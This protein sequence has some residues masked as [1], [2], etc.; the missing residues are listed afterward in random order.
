MDTTNNPILSELAEKTLRSFNTLA[1]ASDDMTLNINNSPI[2]GLVDI[3]L[4]DAIF[5]IA[6]DIHIEPNTAILNIRFRIDGLLYEYAA[7]PLALHPF[8]VARLKIIS[9]LNTVEKRKPQDGNLSYKYLDKTVDIRVAVIPTIHGE[10]IVLR[11]LNTSG[12]LLNIDELNLSAANKKLFQK[13]YT[14]PSGLILNTGPVNSGKTT[15]LYAALQEL[16]SIEKNIMTIEDPVE[17]KLDGI[18]QVQINELQGLNFNIGLRAILRQ[19]PNIVLIG[20][21]RDNDTA[22]TAVRAALTGHL[23]LS[24]LHASNAVNAVLRLLDMQIEPYLLA[25]TL[26]G[27]LSQ[28]LVRKICPDCI[29]SYTP[30]I[31]SAEYNFLQ[32][33]HIQYDKLFHGRGCN[34]CNNS[35]Y[36]GRIAIHE[37]FLAN[38]NI[39][40]AIYNT[41]DSAAI[42]KL[43][44]E[45]GM[46]SL[47]SDGINKCIEQKTTLAEIMRISDDD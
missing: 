7:L 24:T 32:K 15:T 3:I 39:K 14:R 47:L 19:D 17:Y 21:I 46:I 11:L 23:V 16:N 35:G 25:A 20:E 34:K 33:H 44:W 13:L 41:A 28:R 42:E 6:S 22:K 40:N 30:K 10:K 8:I 38:K 9:K 2:V 31:N 43:A 27:C 36:H 37:I 26:A 4:N 45:N 29:E 5:K 12:K 18:N 1:N